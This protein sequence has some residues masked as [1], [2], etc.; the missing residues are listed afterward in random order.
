MG[1]PESGSR[2][3]GR[4]GR[5][6]GAITIDWAFAV[7]I[8]IAFFDYNALATQLVFFVIQALATVGLNASIGHLLVGMRLQRVE[9]GRLG[10]MK[11]LIRAV[12]LSLVIPALFFD[13]D[14]RGLHDRAVGTI[15]LR[16]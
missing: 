9:G 12:L 6:L 13:A 3:I 4:F 2:S 8:S 15:L 1:L 14:Q 16:R 5:R 10:I 11:P 7:G